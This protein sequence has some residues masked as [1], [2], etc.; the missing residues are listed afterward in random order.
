MRVLVIPE[1]PTL[2]QYI[3]K[4]VVEYLL[5]AQGAK[6]R[7]E[8]LRDPHIRGAREALDADLVAAVIRDN[9]MIDL[10]LLIVDRDCDREGHTTKAKARQD[11][12]PAQLLAAVAWQEVEVWMLAAHRN[13]LGE[14][15]SAVREHCDPKEVYAAPFLAR[16]EGPESRARIRAMGEFKARARGVL[17]VCPELADLSARVGEWLARRGAT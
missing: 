17:Q 16:L 9:P 5:G 3:L 13:D 11:E 6:A 1:D 10:F 8:I 4:P 2:D 14:P 7:V 12:H 15:W